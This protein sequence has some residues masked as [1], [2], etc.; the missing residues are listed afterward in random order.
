MFT[1]V[2]KTSNK[3]PPVHRRANKFNFHLFDSDFLE[4]LL[5]FIGKSRYQRYP[6]QHK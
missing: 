4:Q 1:F 5:R 3:N 6:L 2:D